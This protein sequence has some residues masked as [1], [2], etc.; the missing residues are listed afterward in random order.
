MTAPV[1]AGS[2]STTVRAASS[3]VRSGHPSPVSAATSAV[4]VAAAEGSTD[5]SEAAAA[6]AAWATSFF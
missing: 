1:V 6:P 3:A 4:T 5:C 2:L